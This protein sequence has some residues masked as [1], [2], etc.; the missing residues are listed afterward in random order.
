MRVVRN[1]FSTI[2]ATYQIERFEHPSGVIPMSMGEY[3]ALYRAKVDTEASGIALECIFFRSRIEQHGMPEWPAVR[4]D[5]IREAVSGAAE[6]VT[7]EFVH[8][9]ALKIREFGF[10]LR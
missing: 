4:G 5:Q 9:V 8:P 7:G 1:V 6:T 3:D 2:P 10:G